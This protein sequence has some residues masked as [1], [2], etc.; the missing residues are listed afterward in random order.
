M[1]LNQTGSS[2][3]DS[4]TVT[5]AEMVEIGLSCLFNTNAGVNHR[6]L[7]RRFDLLSTSVTAQ[8]ALL[9]QYG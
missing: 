6:K 4:D 2:F 1:G 7:N 3:Y 9:G 8:T 5:V